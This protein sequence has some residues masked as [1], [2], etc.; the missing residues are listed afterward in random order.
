MNPKLTD[1]H[2]CRR[3]I[4]YVRQSTPGQLMHNRESQRR[5]YG[6]ADY[7][8]SLGFQEVETID[9]D[10]GRTASGCVER[11]GFQ[12][13]VTE[14]CAGQVG[15]VFC[16]EASRLARN[17]KD[18]HHLIE[19]CGLVSALVIDPEGMYDPR[20]INDRLLLGLK[21][22]MSE[23]EL[24]LF[25]QRSV[26]AIRQ[27]AQRG[28][29]RFILPVGFCW[30]AHGKIEIDP[31]LRV[32][33]AIRTILRK[34]QELGSARQVHMTFQAGGSLAPALG[35]DPAG[36][37]INWRSPSY[38]NILSVVS[39]PMYAGAYAFG[40]TEVRTRVVGGQARKS[41]GHEKPRE[42]WTVLIKDHHPGYITWEQFERNQSVLS[43]NAYM[44]S[45]MGRKSGRGGR[46]LLAGL[47]R[48][49]RCGRMMGIRYS[50]HDGNTPFFRCRARTYYGLKGCASFNGWRADQAV[51]RELLQA[52]EG[53]AVE[54][55]L[56]AA[57]R[58]EQ[59]DTAWRE[60]LALE[61][62][63]A[64]YEARLAQR[65]YEAVDPDNRL[66]AGELETRWNSALGRVRELQAKME[67]SESRVRATPAV[68]RESLLALAED[69][70]TVWNAPETDMK[71]KQRI[72]RILIQEIVVDFDDEASE[73]VF[74]IH[75][76]GGRHS[77]LRIHK[78]KTGHHNRATKAEAIEVIRRMSGRYEDNQIA[79]TLN[80][81]GFRT[82]YDH[83]WTKARIQNL[84]NKLELPPCNSGQR[85]SIMLTLEQA[86]ERLNT[87]R[88]MIKRLID[89]KIL[90]ATQVI[91][92][93][94]W[95][96]PEE[97]V[98]S[99]AVIT[100]VKIIAARPRIPRPEI[101]DGQELLFSTT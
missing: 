70:P 72:A 100:A 81:L 9:D 68:D 26:E 64:E 41:D 7:A 98:Q 75:W 3:A 94:P 4:V 6:L 76:N 49:G 43:E 25:R 58:V 87:N 32:Q 39:N 34:F 80:R 35:T 62:Q 13:L 88:T 97:S 60:A 50:G 53:P 5:Q 11:P 30:T 91:P 51:S 10:L 44:K 31:D 8:R 56:E 82:G 15:A 69:L 101:E 45:R 21:G 92:G 89:E 38:Y 52:L 59:Q 29:L 85:M 48:C 67:K 40:K 77:E 12:R 14:V 55:A 84:R 66:V 23:F 86:A 19:L 78:N 99:P 28:E 37:R 57:G 16:I 63:Q 73:T 83:T 95:E 65:R 90:P 96:I 2:L 1:E 61:L 36:S 33:Q 42:N 20:L 22:T 74:I 27:K 93:A 47:L 24:N 79:A 46:S 71:L 17:G 18:W 54:A